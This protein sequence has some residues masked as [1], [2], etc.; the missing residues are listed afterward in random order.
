MMDPFGNRE[1]P[2]EYDLSHPERH[3][4]LAPAADYPKEIPEEWKQLGWHLAE[5]NKPIEEL[6]SAC[7]WTSYEQSCTSYLP[8]IRIMHARDN[9]GLWSMGPKWLVK[10]QPNDSTLGNEY[11]TW[12]FLHGQP[13]HTIP[14]VK[15]MR[16]LTD[17]EDPIQ[18]T[19]I[20]R[21]PGKPLA[22][23]WSTLSPEQ[24]SGYRDQMVDILKQ[25]RQFTAPFPQKVNGD[26]LDDVVLICGRRHPP[27]CFRIGFTE[28]E[29]LEDLSETLRAGLS[30]QNDC[31]KD[32]EL[33][34]KK[35]QE[36]KD[37]FPSGSPYTLTHGDLNL[38]NIIV[39]D[40][41][42]QAIIDWELSGY[43]PWW[44]EKYIYQVYG[45]Q[46]MDDLFEGVW[47]RVHPDLANDAIQVIFQ[48]TV[49]EPRLLKELEQNTPTPTPGA[50]SARW[51]E[52]VDLSG[53]EK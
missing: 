2:V 52:K 17:P 33:I 50:A 41:K 49:W 38:T 7:G 31:T 20:S 43:F 39:K 29:W 9:T 12:K 34:E 22:S 25:L 53:Q 28:Q 11:M 37:N 8:R 14:L 3:W 4:E 19:V 21:A 16:R 26:K 27:A 35:L 46:D 47:E 51:F 18:F 36:I 23:I 30:G 42:I 15:E 1:E 32:E 48:K 40:D 6:C 10:D 13:G 44:A 5:H 45:D 24:K